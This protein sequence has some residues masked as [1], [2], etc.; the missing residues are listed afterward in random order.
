MPHYGIPA[1]VGTNQG[2]QKQPL[3][4]VSGF[5]L[6]AKENDWRWGDGGSENFASRKGSEREALG[7]I[8]SRWALP[9]SLAGSYLLLLPEAGSFAPEVLLKGKPKR[10]RVPAFK[11][12]FGSLFTLGSRRKL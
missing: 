7:K 8:G 12:G 5:P 10:E 4:C 6:L 2:K 9:P 3:Y 11:G 1:C